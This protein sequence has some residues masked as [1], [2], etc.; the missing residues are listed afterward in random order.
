[1]I[2]TFFPLFFCRCFPKWQQSPSPPFWPPAS[3]PTSRQSG[4]NFAIS[5]MSNVSGNL[6]DHLCEQC[7]LQ[8]FVVTKKKTWKEKIQNIY[9]DIYA[10]IPRRSW[11]LRYMTST[12]YSNMINVHL[13]SWSSSHAFTCP[14]STARPPPTT[15]CSSIKYLRPPLLFFL[16]LFLPRFLILFCSTMFLP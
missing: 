12:L 14:S 15:H 11:N 13:T 4:R 6:C 16:I 3:S 1:M 5:L 10:R 8:P 7:S 9:A 2:S